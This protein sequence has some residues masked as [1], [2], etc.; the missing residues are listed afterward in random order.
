MKPADFIHLVRI[1]EQAS[2][3]DSRA[4]RWGVAGFTALGYLW[5]VGCFVVAVALLVWTLSA[6][7]QGRIKGYHLAL[8]VTA[9]GLLWTSW[10]ALWLHLDAPE[11]VAIA[12]ADA[13]HLFTTLARIRKKI[14]GP[15]IHHVLLDGSF[16]AS[17]SQIPRFGLLG[18]ATNYLTIGL[19]LLMAIDRSRF[20]A[21]MAHEYGHLRGGHGQFTA[22]IYRT[23]L[24]WT[25]LKQGMR[26][27]NDPIT[28][29]TQA[30]L[31][32]YFPRFLAKT[33][34]L[35]RQDEFEAD[36]IAAKLLGPEVTGAALT[37]IAIKGKWLETAFWPLHWSA[38]ATSP[39][40]IGPFYAMHTLLA[41]PMDDDFVRQSLREAL[42]Q[43]SDE[44]DTHPVL[45]D[46]LEALNVNKQVPT[47]STRPALN[48]LAKGG[49]RWLDLFDKQW[50]RDNASDW[51]LHHAYLSRVKV[52][53]GTLTASIKRNNADEMTQLGDL[54]CRIDSNADVRS[55]Y[56]RALQIT[57]GHTGALHG[58]AH[59]LPESEHAAR[60]DCLGQLFELSV[61]HRWEA[62]CSAVRMLEKQVAKGQLDEYAMKVWRD[63][64]KQANESEERAFAE[65]SQSPCFHSI[66]RH[67]L[68]DFEKGEFQSAMARCKPVA[69]AWLVRKTLKEFAHRRCYLL[70][71]ELPSLND[72][73]RYTLCRG[74]ERTLDL[75][76]QVLVLWA[77]HSPSLQDIQRHAFDAVYVRQL[78]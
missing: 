3:D 5:V 70:F 73:D 68:N 25:R 69:R 76:G 21:V 49:F 55:C 10:R 57:P 28:L 36:R 38:A 32:W 43:L 78:G 1:S 42:I 9:F 46:R 54:Q 20:F 75:P 66:A 19:P 58:L 16:N 74:L 27:N 34:A 13:P 29:T 14:K 67:D 44:K 71:T 18:G 30:F 26:D 31:R 48:L 47:W 53:I 65:L 23:R 50:C 17:I 37:E 56:E 22:W 33:F 60:L 40:P 61:A 24:S 39:Q 35:A 11:G 51:K 12:A 72:E 45:R 4:Y 41:Q 2:A 63:R 59:C 8:L 62:S 7:V 64:L 77:G 6:A 52:G 15:P